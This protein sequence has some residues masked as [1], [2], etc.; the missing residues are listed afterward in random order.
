M[1]V[2]SPSPQSWWLATATG[3]SASAWGARTRYALAASGLPDPELAAESLT[4]LA[5]L[6]RRTWDPPHEALVIEL[7]K[8]GKSIMVAS[9][10]LHEVQAMTD[11]FV[12]IFGGRILALIA[13]Q[14]IGGSRSGEF[15][16]ALD[17]GGCNVVGVL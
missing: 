11:E 4:K 12:L 14:Q 6:P 3:A 15:N 7:G 17:R 10:V 9:H 2:A 8:E 1:A 13:H 5:R 16:G